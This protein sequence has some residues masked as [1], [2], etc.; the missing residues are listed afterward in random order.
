MD[1]PEA[2]CRACGATT[3]MVPWRGGW[4]ADLCTDC[5]EYELSRLEQES[6]R[7]LPTTTA[8]VADE[9]VA[10]P[11]LRMLVWNGI[12]E[13]AEGGPDESALSAAE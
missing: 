1:K 5:T 4:A 8:L 7:N 13:T 11:P 9:T 6:E 10:E 12:E 2:P 3:P